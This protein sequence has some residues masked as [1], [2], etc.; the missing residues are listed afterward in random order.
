LGQLKQR[1]DIQFDAQLNQ[2]LNRTLIADLFAG[3]MRTV[4]ADLTPIEIWQNADIEP[5]S[6]STTEPFMIWMKAG[7]I[8]GLFLASPWVFFQLWSFVAAGL[9]PHEQRYVYVFLPFSLGLFL[10]G[11]VLAFFFLFEPVLA[12]LFSFNAQLG[13]SPEPRMNDWLTFVMFLPLGFGIAF[14]L[15]LVMLLLNRVGILSIKDYLEKWRLSIM[16]IFV[17]SMILTP[18][19]PISMIMLAIPLTGLYF[20]GIALCKWMPYGRNPFGA[21]AAD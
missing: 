2:R 18:A 12:F 17:L 15:P 7:I 6:L 14:Q 5:Q 21:A 19:D 3:Q 11:A 10:S 1:L 16:I 8:T 20:L 4:R 13:I 9:Y